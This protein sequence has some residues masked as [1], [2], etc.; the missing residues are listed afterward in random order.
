MST[1]HPLHF[2]RCAPFDLDGVHCRSILSLAAAVQS[3]D[4]AR[5]AQIAALNADELLAL[6]T[7]GC[8]VI[9]EGFWKGRALNDAEVFDLYQ[10][11]YLAQVEQNPDLA[12]DMTQLTDPLEVFRMKEPTVAG[13]SVSLVEARTALY[14]QVM[15]AQQSRTHEQKASGENAMNP[16]NDL[17]PIFEASIDRQNWPDPKIRQEHNLNVVKI[18]P[19]NRA[20]REVDP[21]TLPQTTILFNDSPFTVG[22]AQMTTDIL[23]AYGWEAQEPTEQLGQL[24]NIT[25]VPIRSCRTITRTEWEDGLR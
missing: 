21:Q 2:T 17:R 20:A 14:Y 1:A 6:I 24:A 25:L 22:N 10:R 23:K 7:S 13:L 11:A 19:A 15:A 12:E 18:A 3:E 8:T 16:E 4:P 5:A 9:A